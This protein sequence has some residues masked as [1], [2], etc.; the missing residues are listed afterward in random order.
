MLSKAAVNYTGI[1][2]QTYDDAPKTRLDGSLSCT[3][4][5][6]AASNKLISIK[7]RGKN[8]QIPNKNFQTLFGQPKNSQILQVNL[9]SEN[10]RSPDSRTANDFYKNMSKA[11]DNQ[12]RNIKDSESGKKKTGAKFTL[13][14]IRNS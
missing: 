3:F 8:Q 1:E 13:N 9:T 5:N 2:D 11:N 6:R 4:D 14:S 12:Y 7:N 10:S